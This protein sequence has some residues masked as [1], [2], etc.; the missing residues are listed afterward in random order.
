MLCNT[1]NSSHLYQESVGEVTGVFD[2]S[3]RQD[4]EALMTSCVLSFSVAATSIFR[5]MGQHV[6]GVTTDVRP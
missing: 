1:L 3:E 5:N 4:R 2:A 6:W